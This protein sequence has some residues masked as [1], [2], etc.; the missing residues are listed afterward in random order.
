MLDPK[1]AERRITD[2]MTRSLS[3][4]FWTYECTYTL[5]TLYFQNWSFGQ[6]AFKFRCSR[7][8]IAGKID[9]LI[10]WKVLEKRDID[11]KLARERVAPRPRKPAPPPRAP[12][13]K[14]VSAPPPPPTL[15]KEV[16]TPASLGGGG[17]RFA[18]GCKWP[19]GDEPPFKWCNRKIYKKSYC[20]GHYHRAYYLPDK[21]QRAVKP[22][23]K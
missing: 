2:L 5:L 8:K 19:Y 16:V 7:S 1:E 22:K 10:R 14:A 21:R 18:T 20:E 6:I 9:R 17:D 4:D 11:K 12:R 3:N 13:S 15:S 23:W